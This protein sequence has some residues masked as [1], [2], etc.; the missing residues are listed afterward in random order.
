MAS[1]NSTSEDET[2]ALPFKKHKKKT[3]L[4]FNQ[5]NVIL[6]IYQ[7]E[8]NKYPKKSIMDIIK[9]ISNITGVSQR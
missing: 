9:T 2:F 6:N 4:S 5:K 3:Y 7:K 1:V 8:L